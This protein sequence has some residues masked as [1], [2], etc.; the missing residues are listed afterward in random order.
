[1]RR[2]E[3]V[4][5][6]VTIRISPLSNT[7]TK[8]SSS[9]SWVDILLQVSRVRQALGSLHSNKKMIFYLTVQWISWLHCLK[10]I[11]IWRLLN[12]VTNVK[13]GR[14]PMRSQLLGHRLPPMSFIRWVHLV[15]CWQQGFGVDARG[16]I[17]RTQVYLT[18][19]HFSY[20]EVFLSNV[21]GQA[22]L[23]SPLYKRLEH[24]TSVISVVCTPLFCPT[25]SF[26][27]SVMILCSLLQK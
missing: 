3:N 19:N 9:E 12:K 6:N 27:A 17:S 4:A 22:V 5:D 2:K 23:Y 26:M 18:N 13:K 25:L 16:K 10:K 20:S 11:A 7:A 14:P 15:L 21:F 8:V 1:M 24:V